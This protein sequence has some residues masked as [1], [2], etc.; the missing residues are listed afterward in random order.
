M[1]SS[2]QTNNEDAE[3]GAAPNRQLRLGICLGAFGF[4]K[5]GRG[6]R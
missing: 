6:G 1:Q 5:P 4:H 2:D 3:R